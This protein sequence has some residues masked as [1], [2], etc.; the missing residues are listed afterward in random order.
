MNSVLN[1]DFAILFSDFLHKNI[2][3]GY[4]FELP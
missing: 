4:L 3:C 1:D 2:C